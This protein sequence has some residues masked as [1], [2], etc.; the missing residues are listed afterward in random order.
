[1]I[2]FLREKAKKACNRG[3]AARKREKE[4]G[5]AISVASSMSKKSQRNG[6]TVSLNATVPGLLGTIHEL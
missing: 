4:E 6:I 1:M 5:F 2:L 3:T